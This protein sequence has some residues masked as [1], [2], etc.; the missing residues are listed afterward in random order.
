MRPLE[1]V[2]MMMVVMVEN[3]YPHS[4]DKDA[5]SVFS[6]ATGRKGFYLYFLFLSV[7]QNLAE[8]SNGT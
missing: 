3:D 4:G 8:R 6:T 5:F 7:F 2:H 1:K